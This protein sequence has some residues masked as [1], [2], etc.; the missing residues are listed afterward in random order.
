MISARNSFRLVMASA[1]F[2][3][4]VPS[5]W[6]QAIDI[7]SIVTGADGP[8]TWMGVHYA[9]QFEA[10]VDNS[11]AEMERDSL[12]LNAGHRFDM[13]DDVFVIGNIAY[14]GSYYDFSNGN[15]KSQL[16]WSDIHQT[17]LMLGRRVPARSGSGPPRP[18][19]G[20]HGV[21]WPSPAGR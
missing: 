15:D 11:T 3:V 16:L 18:R 13:G 14:H 4:L 6:G 10:D 5:A 2:M 20:S 8:N 19:A 17:T 1:V 7:P 9:H 12:Q 21:A